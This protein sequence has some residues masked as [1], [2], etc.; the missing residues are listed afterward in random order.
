MQVHGKYKKDIWVVFS[1]PIDPG[2]GVENLV[3]VETHEFVADTVD[4]GMAT[5]MTRLGDRD[6]PC[7]EGAASAQKQLSTYNM[8]KMAQE[9][10]KAAVLE[11]DDMLRAECYCGGVSLLIKRADHTENAISKLDRFKPKEQN[12]YMAFVCTCRYCRLA[13]GNTI[14]PWIY[15]PPAIVINPHTDKP[16]AQHHEV[17]TEEGRKMNAGLNLKPFWSS[18][19]SCRSF[20]GTCG[21]TVFYSTD[22]RQEI[23]NVAAGLLRA[24]EGAMAR[25]WLSWQWGR[26]AWKDEATDHELMEAWRA[27]AEDA[28]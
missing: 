7:F 22:K 21:A 11:A 25:R 27:T 1:G 9:S 24:A 14:S 18:L 16:V 13:T 4:G 10:F 28:S 26:T 3:H 12:K 15:V 20:C 19:N 2:T 17:S 6:V 23:V 5:F 8:K